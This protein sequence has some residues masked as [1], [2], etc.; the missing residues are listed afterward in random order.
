MPVSRAPYKRGWNDTKS[1][2]SMPNVTCNGCGRIV[3]RYKTFTKYRSF[4]IN[5]PVV[6]K[7]LEPS[8]I[9]MFSRK[10]YMCPACA[11]HRGI[12]R[13]GKSGQHKQRRL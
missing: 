12:S 8:A 5:D 10:E 9:H 11:R 1:R 7:M 4:R 3:P 13:A 6:M 2:G